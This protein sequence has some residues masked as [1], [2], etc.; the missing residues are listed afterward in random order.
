MIPL[1]C[2]IID[3]ERLARL[4]IAA[5]LAEA[6][7]CTVVAEASNAS[8]AVN[9]IRM[10]QPDVIFLDINMPGANG[11]DL[12][13]QLDDCPLVVFVTA[14]DQ[15]AIRAFEVNALDYLLK[16]VRP[17]RLGKT[18]ALI[19]EQLPK[20]QGSRIFIST[21]D[22]GKFIKL[23]D[24]FLVRS[25]DH[26]VRIYHSTGSNMLHQSLKDFV[27]RLPAPDFFLANR[28][29]VIRLEAVIEIGNLSRGRYELSLPADETVVVS[30]RQSV[31]WRR[32]ISG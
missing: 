11:F 23:Q 8:Q 17:K 12:L 18:L 24:I 20:A 15:F 26:Y 2:L 19:R 30:E 27:K 3:D 31:V 13:A 29:E 4:E 5:L 32:E 14:Y 25:Y 16:P 6:G 28:S 9:L 7:D 10:H 21:S 22:G 1:R